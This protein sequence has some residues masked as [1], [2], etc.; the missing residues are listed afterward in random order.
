MGY[1]DVEVAIAR[2]KK[3]MDREP[4]FGPWAEND[5]IAKVCY[6]IVIEAL[7]R[8]PSADVTPVVRCKDCI[9]QQTCRFA[10]WLGMDGYCSQ[11]EKDNND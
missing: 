4:T 8:L 9:A 11:G 10:Q 1:V 3:Q 7:E 6:G 2:V 5:K